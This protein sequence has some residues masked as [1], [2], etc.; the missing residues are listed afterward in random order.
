[1]LKKLHEKQKFF[2]EHFDSIHRH[3]GDYLVAVRDR[4][5]YTIWWALLL[6]RRTNDQ[7]NSRLRQR[8]LRGSRQL[9]L[10]VQL[11]GIECGGIRHLHTDG[12][13]VEKTIGL[14]VASWVINLFIEKI[15]ENSFSE[16]YKINLRPNQGNQNHLSK[17]TKL[18]IQAGIVSSLYC[19]SEV[20]EYSYTQGWTLSFTPNDFR[21]QLDYLFLDMSC[22]LNPIIYTAFNSKL[23]D[24]LLIILRL[25]KAPVT[26]QVTTQVTT[27]VT[28]RAWWIIKRKILNTFISFVSKWMTRPKCELFRLK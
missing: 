28:T 14:C 18:L 2:S 7:W 19:L 23:R 5:G 9:D 13:S 11:G 21:W 8:T 22:L 10:F 4:A 3:F 6:G 1:M 25:K 24:Q 15:C 20:Y 17:E 26:G 27:H 12:D 16:N